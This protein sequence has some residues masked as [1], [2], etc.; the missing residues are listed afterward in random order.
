[1]NITFRGNQQVVESNCMRN[2]AIPFTISASNECGERSEA[3]TIEVECECKITIEG[4]MGRMANHI[5]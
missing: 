2:V 3:I 5:A 4:N 1:M